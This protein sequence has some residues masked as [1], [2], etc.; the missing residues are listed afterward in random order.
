M[1]IKQ[2][3]RFLAV[4]EKG[5]ISS[6]AKHLQLTQQA[7]ST[8]I[9]KLEKS[10]GLR[11]F[12]RSPGGI[13]KPT[14]YGR[15]LT[16][17]ARSQIAAI[18][19]SIQEL[20]AIRDA[21]SGTIAVGVGETVTSD[22][23]ATAISRF[24]SMRPEIRINVI[25]GY[26]ELL[27]ERLREGE[28]DFVAGGI[29]GLQLPEDLEQELLY[30][31]D[32]IVVARANHPLAG[33]K[34]VSLKQLSE[35]TWMV[36]YARSSDLEVILDTFSNEHIELPKRFIG[37]DAYMLGMNLILSNDF[38]IMVQPAMVH[39]SLQGKSAVLC[40]I[41]IDRPTVRRHARLIY[42]ANRPMSPAAHALFEEVKEVC[43]ERGL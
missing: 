18:D 37:T 9:A 3:K 23:I 39:H 5:S 36:P 21:S 27:L 6:A 17:H 8:D 1:E 38:L 12:D 41:D 13:T 40:R 20:H 30:S 16:R 31:S 43:Q 28:F 29:G 4:V 22:I 26:S 32:D 14:A 19:R 15:A 2:L 25:E 10:I 24:H 34:N 11:L 35:Y 7:L 42:P 33:Q